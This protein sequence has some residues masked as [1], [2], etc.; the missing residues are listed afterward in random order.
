MTADHNLFETETMAELCTRQGRLGEAIAI[1]RRLADVGSDAQA[2]KRWRARL[3][4]LEAEWRPG[5]DAEAPAANVALPMPPGIDV[6]VGDDQVT[7]AW[8]LRSGTTSPAVEVL[9]IQRTSAGIETVKR[10]I[11]VDTLAGRL[12]ILAPGVHSARAAAGTLT[13]ARFVP[14]VRSGA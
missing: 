9:I 12:G 1:Y 2:R 14:V 11:P 5:R 6:H 3:V 8:A 4:A 13:E 7:V 10:T